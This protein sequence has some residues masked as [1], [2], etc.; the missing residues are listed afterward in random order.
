[1]RFHKGAF[2]LAKKLGADILPMYIH[3]QGHVLPKKDFMLRRGK[4][5]VEVGERVRFQEST[6]SNSKAEK[7]NGIDIEENQ[8]ILEMTHRMRHQYQAHYAEL[9]DRLETED[10]WKS[11]REYQKIYEL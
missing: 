5:Y 11:Y 10:Y 4:M 1:M 6:A 9:C 2:Y 3:G 8:Q 7:I